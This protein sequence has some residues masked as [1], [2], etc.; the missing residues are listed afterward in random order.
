MGVFSELDMERDNFHSQEGAPAGFSV[1]DEA[2]TLESQAFQMQV[3]TVEQPAA[4]DAVP[5]T[6]TDA[7]SNDGSGTGVK[8]VPEEKAETAESEDDKRKAHEEAEA[9][10]KAEF[11]AK[12]AAKN[13]AVQEQLDKLAAMSDEEVLAASMQRVSEDTEK[14]TR[15]NMK[16]C[17]AEHIQTKCLED[18][19]FARLTMHPKKNMIHCFQY[20]SRKAWDYIQDELKANGI[21]PGPGQQ[22]YG[23]DIPDGLCYQWAEDYFRDPDAKE[24]HED[25]EKFV[26]KPYTGGTSKSKTAGKKDKGKKKA[27]KKPAEAPKTEPEPKPKDNGG[28]M[29]LLDAA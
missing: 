7:V 5:E 26:P 27:E 10:R 21:K 25:E 19:A 2:V 16:E 3:S 6:S 24:D 28:Q 9:K 14:L 20:I 29:S 23:C 22:A 18:P 17:V 8:D 1:E 12:Q 15:R 13:A 11:D 4:V